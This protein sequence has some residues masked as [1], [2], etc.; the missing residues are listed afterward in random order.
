MKITI[1]QTRQIRQ[2][3]PRR[4]E[5]TINTAELNL[6]TD[7]EDLAAEAIES[8]DRLLYPENY[9]KAEEIN[10]TTLEPPKEDSNDPVPF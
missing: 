3:E 6:E 10:V 7:W 9:V 1:S 2:Y 5:V 4:I 8:I